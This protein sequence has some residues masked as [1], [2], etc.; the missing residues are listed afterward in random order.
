MK[1]DVDL[2]RKILEQVEV[3]SGVFK[4]TGVRVEGYDKDVSDYH[5]RMLFDAGLLHGY[6]RTSSRDRQYQTLVTHLT[7]QG[8]D[9]LEAVRAGKEPVGFTSTAR[10]K[11]LQDIAG[12]LKELGRSFSPF[13][14]KIDK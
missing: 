3:H 9:Y 4:G 11:A 7:V 1:L 13:G 12:E 2:C 8:H 5:V 10:T 14:I 6:D